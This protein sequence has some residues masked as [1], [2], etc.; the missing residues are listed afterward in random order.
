MEPHLDA[1]KIYLVQFMAEVLIQ[2]PQCKEKA[3]VLKKDPIKYFFGEVIATCSN[4]G[5]NKRFNTEQCAL[6]HQ[7]D[8]YFGYELWLQSNFKGNVFWAYNKQHL[9]F[10]KE[11]IG[12]TDRKR[13]ISDMRNKSLGSRLPKWMTKKNHRSQLLKLI[14]KLDI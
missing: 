12:S 13:D 6:G 1:Y 9:S 4:C 8:P 3:R 11:H 7:Y 10:L 14:E 5:F 2:C